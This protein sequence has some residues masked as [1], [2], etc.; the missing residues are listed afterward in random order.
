MRPSLIFISPPRT[1]PR[2]CV[3]R[4]EQEIDH[5]TLPIYTAVPNVLVDFTQNFTSEF[6]SIA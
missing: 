1:L 3:M 2:Y 4:V 5:A 6:P